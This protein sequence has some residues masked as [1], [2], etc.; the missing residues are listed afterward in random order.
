MNLFTP[1]RISQGAF[2]DI[3]AG[4]GITG[5]EALSRGAELLFSVEVDRRTCSNIVEHSRN[6]GV[7]NQVRMLKIDAR[8]CMAVVRRL[9][10]KDCLLSCCFADP[11]F[12]EGMAAGLLPGIGHYP[13]IW[14]DDAR[15]II[16]T[17]DS[18]P[19]TAEG[20]E[21]MEKRRA[22]NAWLWIYG[23]KNPVNAD[24]GKTDN[25]RPDGP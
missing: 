8:R 7:E 5:F 22:G 18:L 2:L 15:I 12:I 11:P 24:E 6:F 17:P 3:C 19:E 16:R 21:F 20:L 1:E 4:S 25:E 10:P 23:P 14:T 9:L 13:D